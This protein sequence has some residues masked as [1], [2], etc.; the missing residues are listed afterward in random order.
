MQPCRKRGLVVAKIAPPQKLSDVAKEVLR[1]QW[2]MQKE[3]EKHQPLRT[4]LIDFDLAMPFWAPWWMVGCGGRKKSGKTTV[5]VCLGLSFS[6][7]GKRVMELP[8]EEQPFQLAI[9]AMSRMSRTIKRQDFRGLKITDEGFEELEHIVKDLDEL[10]NYIAS[11]IRRAAD[12]YDY[13]K[14]MP[15]ADRPDIV[16]ADYMQL[17]QD[18]GE[19]MAVRAD[20]VS[21]VFMRLRNEFGIGSIVVYQLGSKDTQYGG[22]SIGRDCDVDINCRAKIDAIT[23]R[24]IPNMMVVEIMAAREVA[25]SSFE[26]VFSGEHSRLSDVL[27]PMIKGLLEDPQ[28]VFENEFK[29]ERTAS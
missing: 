29:K 5:A 7:G 27:P 11:D 24:P 13:I 14:A 26:L 16:I 28:L 10:E 4:N 1:K 8:L 2:Q 9:R 12:L 6:Q 19:N 25:P 21:S 23:K 17:F 15:S 18:R 3:P 22:S 20:I